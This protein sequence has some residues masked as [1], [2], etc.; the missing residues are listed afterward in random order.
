MPAAREQARAA[1]DRDLC[2]LFEVALGALPKVR[3][4]VALGQI[5]H[6]AA[7]RAMGLPPSSTKRCRGPWLSGY[8]CSP[9]TGRIDQR[10]VRG[11][12]RWALR[13]ADD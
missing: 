3:V 8:H 9:I 11:G 7:A 13:F 6:V 1:R 4:V 5:A 12:V 2:R 10:D